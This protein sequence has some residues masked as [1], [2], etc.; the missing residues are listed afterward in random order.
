[1]SI[2]QASYDIAIKIT[3]VSHQAILVSTL[4]ANNDLDFKIKVIG[5]KGQTLEIP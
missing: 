1:M 2:L 3:N 5:F 4:K